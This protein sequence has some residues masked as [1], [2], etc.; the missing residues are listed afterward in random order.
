M[1]S[2]PLSKGQV[3]ESC[4]SSGN[5]HSS[6]QPWLCRVLPGVLGKSKTGWKWMC[7]SH[8]EGNL[9]WA[10]EVKTPTPLHTLC[11]S[12]QWPVFLFSRQVQFSVTSKGCWMKVFMSSVLPALFFSSAWLKSR[13]RQINYKGIFYYK[14]QK[15]GKNPENWV[16]ADTQCLPSY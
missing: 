12:R 4:P 8:N 14:I 6:G 9:C 16:E 5:T 2:R 7:H 3:C 13:H 15:A 10:D 1:L 11:L